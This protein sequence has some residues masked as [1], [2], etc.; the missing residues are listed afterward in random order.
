MFC[1]DNFETK[2]PVYK[3]QLG[4]ISGH[5]PSRLL[6]SSLASAPKVV[7]AEDKYVREIVSKMIF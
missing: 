4:T 1:I 7:M 3:N 5:V 2:T 6:S